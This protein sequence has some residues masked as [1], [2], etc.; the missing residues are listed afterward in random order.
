MKIQFNLDEAVTQLKTLRDLVRFSVSQFNAADLLY[1]HGTDNSLDE[2]MN[3]VL[4]SLHLPPDVDLSL[5]DARLTQTEK[6]LI[7]DRLKRRVEEHV[8]VPYL[9]NEAWFG[10]LGFYVDER[11]I[12]PR[13][14]IAELVDEQFNPWVEEASVSNILDLCTGSGCIAI[15][16]AISFP[17]AMV[18]AI[19]DSQ[20]ALDVAKIN[21]DRFDLSDQVTL[22]RSNLFEAVPNKQY[23]IIISNPPYVSETDYRTLPS[24]Y[25]HEPHTALVAG[26]E[27]LEIVLKILKEA[28]DYLTPQGILVVEVGYLQERMEAEFPNAPFTWLQFENGGE[29]VFLLTA[30]EL[31]EFQSQLK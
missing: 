8:P 30:E 29:G 27:G 3:L 4:A 20:D 9:V 22:I 1:G 5:L 17:M 15:Q 7:L 12:I 11:V 6:K 21:V 28:K 25:H 31:L 2:A 24:E 10:G 14:P 19:D 26:N 23:D 18:D 16:T 13:S